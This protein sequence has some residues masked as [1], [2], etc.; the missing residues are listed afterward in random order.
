MTKFVCIACTNSLPPQISRLVRFP[1]SLPVPSK[2]SMLRNIPWMEGQSDFF[3]DMLEDHLEEREFQNGDLV[4]PS[5]QVVDGIILITS[6]VLKLKLASGVDNWVRYSD[7]IFLEVD[8]SLEEYIPRG[9]VINEVGTVL[10]VPRSSDVYAATHPV[11]I[12]HISRNSLKRVFRKF[13]SVEKR[14]IHHI[15]TSVA[16]RVLARSPAY[17]GYALDQLRNVFEYS[18]VRL[19]PPFA[20]MDNLFAFKFVFIIYG[21]VE[22]AQQ[23]GR[24]YEGPM[25]LPSSLTSV[26]TLPYDLNAYQLYDEQD[27]LAR[28]KL[29]WTKYTILCFVSEEPMQAPK[30]Y[31]EFL[32]PP[33]EPRHHHHHDD[34]S[35]LRESKIIR[36][37]QRGNDSVRIP[38]AKTHWARQSFRG[39]GALSP[40]FAVSPASRHISEEFLKDVS[41][42]GS[43]LGLGNSGKFVIQGRKVERKKRSTEWSTEEE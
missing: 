41:A 31:E 2:E 1:F 16:I 3:F 40:A 20:E 15:A 18:Y 17:E 6:G 35:S 34:Q 19:L 11:R 29:D 24:I 4:C 38:A 10:N 21:M 30:M 14:L 7:C 26:I 43:S 9:N 32:P 42:S 37:S 22:D 28:K 23:R 12:Y 27:F 33:D 39:K 8:D 5:D 36:L 25:L 13:P